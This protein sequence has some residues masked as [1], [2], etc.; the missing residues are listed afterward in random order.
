MHY[1]L[2]ADV[3]KA[4]IPNQDGLTAMSLA[5]R[6]NNYDSINLLKEHGIAPFGDLDTQ[7]YNLNLISLVNQDDLDL[8]RILEEDVK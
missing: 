6:Q 4:D 1:L 7:G 8:Y 2:Q 3:S 5:F